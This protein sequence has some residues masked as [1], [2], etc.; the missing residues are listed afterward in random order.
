MTNLVINLCIN[1]SH[2]LSYKKNIITIL[3]LCF[4]G[5]YGKAQSFNQYN[6]NINNG[7]PSNHV[8][9]VLKD[10]HGYLWLN[11]ENGVVKYNGYGMKVFDLS[12]GMANN[13]VWNLF[14]DKTGKIWLYTISN[15]LG[16]IFNDKYKKVFIDAPEQEIYPNKLFENEDAIFFLCHPSGSNTCLKICKVKNDTLRIQLMPKDASLFPVINNKGE[17][18]GVKDNVVYRL[19]IGNRNE[20]KRI[21][22][23]ELNSKYDISYSSYFFI[24]DNLITTND[25][26]IFAVNLKDT[27]IKNILFH[28]K[29]NESVYTVSG[30]VYIMTNKCVYVVDKEMKITNIFPVEKII[31]GRKNGELN[32]TSFLDDKFWGKYITTST[33]GVYSEKIKTNFFHLN[34]DLQNYYYKGSCFDKHFWWNK[35]KK[36]LAIINGKN[37]VHYLKID[38]INT[39]ETIKPFNKQNAILSTERAFYQLNLNKEIIDKKW[40]MIVGTAP[41]VMNDIAL[42]MVLFDT[43]K[44][45]AITRGIGFEIFLKKNDKFISHLLDSQR[46]KGMYYDTLRNFF[47]VYNNQKISVY[48][49]DKKLFTADDTILSALGIKKIEKILVDSKYGNIFIKDIDKIFVFNFNT[50]SCTEIF[51]NIHLQNSFCF[52]ENNTLVTVGKFG[53]SFCKITG[54]GTFSEPIIYRNVKNLSYSYISDAQVTDNEVLLNTDKGVYSVNIPVDSEQYTNKYNYSEIPY[55]LTTDYRDS[56]NDTKNGDTILIDQKDRKLLFDII[57]PIGNGTVKYTYRITSTGKG[58]QELNSNELYLPNLKPD[59]YYTLSLVANDDVWRSRQTNIHLYIVPYWW[60][61]TIGT[62][63]TYLSAFILA[64]LLIMSIIYTTRRIV[65]RKQAKKNLQLELKNLHLA[66]ELKSIHAQ[67]NPHFIFN[68]LSTGLYFIKKEK[69]KEAYAHISA[70]SDLLRTYIK[71]SR[72]KY[73]SIAD[74]ITNLRNY[75]HLQQARFENKFDY[76]IV[77]P[78]DTAMDKIQIPSLLLQPLVENSITHGLYHKE[79]KGHLKIEFKIDLIKNT[80][81]CIIDDDGIGREQSKLYDRESSINTKSYGSDLIKELINVFNNYEQTKITIE[82]IDKKPPFT[83]TTVILNIN[84]PPY[85]K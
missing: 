49:K 18:Y 73:I 54:N 79:E 10:K 17:L 40:Q 59:N 60:Q 72:E 65:I 48:K 81:V 62:R 41:V 29:T 44:A 58:W 1:L 14:E 80:V 78:P 68:T 39:I 9:G 61:T 50:F 57:N 67:I 42:D 16:Y 56:I 22:S 38:S 82:Y 35:S 30:N 69:V 71:S 5:Y 3:C 46:Y 55:K 74:E 23:D 2:L 77:V 45:Y 37:T 75:I 84:N 25:K 34:F 19:N 36:T 85:E 64:G 15:Q 31:P 4:V 33:Q 21:C 7:L 63:I 24:N 76:T 70:F 20:Y 28:S 11:T 13:D 66:L 53:V 52:L 6:L 47:W 8:Y 32:I 27:T 26:N 12:C 83:G 43:G 51:K